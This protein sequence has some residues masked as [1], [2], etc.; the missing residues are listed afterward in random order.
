MP[1]VLWDLLW[2][3]FFTHSKK[4]VKSKIILTSTRFCKHLLTIYPCDFCEMFVPSIRVRSL[5]IYISLLRL[6]GFCMGLFRFVGE[7]LP[8]CLGLWGDGILTHSYW[9][10][11]CLLGFLGGW[12][13]THLYR[14]FFI[15]PNFQDPAIYQPGFHGMSQLGCSAWLM[16]GG[17]PVVATL[18]K[19]I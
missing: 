5:R 6:P 1:L 13:T 14:D 4:Y 8:G 15:S 12:N 10:S 11:G 19:I 16:S 9:D 3:I 2:F 17:F 7:F 18:T